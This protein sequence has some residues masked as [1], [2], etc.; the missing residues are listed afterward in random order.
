MLVSLWVLRV[1]KVGRFER[2]V[3]N[4]LFLSLVVSL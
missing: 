4:T 2:F 1:N 3:L